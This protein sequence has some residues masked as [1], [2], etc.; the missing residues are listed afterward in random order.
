MRHLEPCE[1]FFS[2]YLCHFWVWLSRHKAS[3]VWLSKR[4][5]LS[6]AVRAIRPSSMD[7]WLFR[8]PAPSV[9]WLN[10]RKSPER[11][12]TAGDAACVARHLQLTSRHPC[13]SPP[14]P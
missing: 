11:V 6:G 9:V 12:V 14:L 5:T 4:N 1:P 10:R 13:S 8:Q 7:V 3:M 2:A